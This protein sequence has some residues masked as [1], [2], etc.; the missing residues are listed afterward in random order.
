MP[1]YQTGGDLHGSVHLSAVET[2]LLGVILIDS[3]RI[4]LHEF[5]FF[6]HYRSSHILVSSPPL[7]IINIKII[8]KIILHHHLH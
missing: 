3:K 5:T 8:L 1:T 6:L 7:T 2:D 4:E